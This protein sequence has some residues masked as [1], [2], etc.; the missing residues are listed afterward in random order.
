M[1]YPYY[2]SLKARL[3]DQVE[4]LKDIQKFNDQYSGGNLSECVA[5]LE[6]PETVNTP[7]ITKT[8]QRET[9]PM[10][11]H[12]VSKIMSDKDGYVTDEQYLQHDQVADAVNTAI[13]EYQLVYAG[14]NLARP[15]QITGYQDNVKVRG[16]LVTK[17]FINIRN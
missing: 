13:K 15:V 4:A 11:I 8:T 9:V 5:L 6:F 16:W 14:E 12:I 2:S 1:F 17:I 10:C 3:L 7:Y